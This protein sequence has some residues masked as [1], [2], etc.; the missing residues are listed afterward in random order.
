MNPLEVKE[1]QGAIRRR[2]RFRRERHPQQNAALRDR[3]LVDFAAE[4]LTFIADGRIAVVPV[5]IILFRRGRARLMSG[6]RPDT[7]ESE[8]EEI[9][10]EVTEPPLYRVLIHN[11]DFTPKTFVIEILMQVFNKPMD[12]ATSIMWHTHNGGT[13]L[14]GIYPLEVAET[15][16]NMVTEAAR[17]SGFPLRL[18]V[19]ED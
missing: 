11:D 4:A 9:R 2:G 14:C 18:T 17:A 3:R 15:K 7:H 13:G 10:D 16:V 12:E 6:T 8:L 1:A 19:E 5:E